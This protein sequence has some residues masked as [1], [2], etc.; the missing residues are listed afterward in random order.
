MDSVVILDFDDLNN[1]EKGSDSHI[2]ISDKM[3]FFNFISDFKL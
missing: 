3:T 2:L 1:M